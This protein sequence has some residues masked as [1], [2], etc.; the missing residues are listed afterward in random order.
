M[1]NEWGSDS[2][3]GPIEELVNF[4]ARLFSEGYQYHSLNTYRST[5]ASIHVPI[6]GM[7]I[8]QHPMVTRLLKGVF[9]ARPPLPRYSMMWD[10]S[11]VLAYLSNEKLE[12]DSSLKSVT[13]KT[14]VL[15]VL[16]RPS[17]SVDVYW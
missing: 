15:L 7:S 17:R 12:Q 6:D 5:I 9:H 2:I 1:C 3:H 14:V 10:I 8:G 11:T 16:S 4:L 13:L